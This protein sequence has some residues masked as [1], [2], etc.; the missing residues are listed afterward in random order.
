[1]NFHTKI[2]NNDKLGNAVVCLGI[3]GSALLNALVV[4]CAYF[5]G[6][7]KGFD[8]YE[9]YIEKETEDGSEE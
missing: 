5:R 9:E 2:T 8:V 3:V 6:V 1:M 4:S 7:R